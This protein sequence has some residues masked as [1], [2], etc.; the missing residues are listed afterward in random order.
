MSIS[1]RVTRILI[2]DDDT[3]LRAMIGFSL[4]GV[5]YEVVSAADGREGIEKCRAGPADLVV[6]DLYMQHQEGLETIQ[7]LRKEFPG[8]P[9]IAMSGAV[10]ANTML[11]IATKLGVARVLHKPFEFE[12][13]LKA[14]EETL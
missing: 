6:T 4:Q 5:G 7:M 8:I 14:I 10:L 9:I 1:G 2:I 13:L 12:E 3:T 11:S